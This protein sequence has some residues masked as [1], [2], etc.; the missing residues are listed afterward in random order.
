MGRTLVLLVF[1]LCVSCFCFVLLFVSVL[2]SI[3]AYITFQYYMV[4]EKTKLFHSL[5]SALGLW[6]CL[7]TIGTL[8]KSQFTMDNVH[9]LLYASH[10]AVRY[11]Q[12]IDI[13]FFMQCNRGESLGSFF[14][15]FLPESDPAKIAL[16]GCG[17]SVATEPVAEISH[18]W[19]I[20]QVWIVIHCSCH[21]NYWN[22]ATV[23]NKYQVL[24]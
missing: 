7:W 20:S 15:D 14:S 18:Q 17:C 22:A 12:T 3:F 13:L 2:V 6:L 21:C 10:T 8:L 19:N 23:E 9:W 1:G 5:Y 11:T 4:Y 16:I 24:H